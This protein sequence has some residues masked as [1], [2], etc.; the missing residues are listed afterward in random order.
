MSL[1][2]VFCGN[3]MER[4]PNIAF[5]AMSFLFKIRDL[6]YPFEKRLRTFGIRAGSTVIDYGCGPGSYL[7]T[8]SQLVG[9][10]GRVYAVDVHELAIES[11]KRMV[12]KYDMRNV[13]PVLVNGYTCHIEDHVADLIYAVDMFH[14]IK[15]S[16]PFLRELHRLLK[17]DGTLIID[18]GHQ[19]REDTKRKIIN[20]KLWT[21]VQE[22]K[23]HLRCAKARGA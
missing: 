1:R 4:M 14:M 12:R 21:I 17:P 16:G 19:P 15:D 8:A 23:D 13:V 10:E 20:S 6:F 9:E 18:D 2:R 11:V 5:R 3:E 22:T 7:R